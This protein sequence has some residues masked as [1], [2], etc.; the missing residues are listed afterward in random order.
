M[1]CN[2]EYIGVVAVEAGRIL[3]RPR[4][5]WREMMAVTLD[6][7]AALKKYDGF[8]EAGQGESAECASFQR[9]EPL[10]ET[11][12]LPRQRTQQGMALA[13]RNL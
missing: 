3:C 10:A 11:A 1:L 12:A 13:G 9:S 4:F 8:A 7:A 6:K 2:F 5:M